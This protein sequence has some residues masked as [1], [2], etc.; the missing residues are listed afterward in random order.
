MVKSLS[1]SRSVASTVVAACSSAT[2][3]PIR[4][5]AGPEGPG[6][7]ARSSVS[8][9]IARS[10]QLLC[11]LRFRGGSSNP[12]LA[13]VKE[14][15]QNHQQQESTRMSSQ[16]VAESGQ[17]VVFIRCYREM[18]LAVN[19]LRRLGKGRVTPRPENVVGK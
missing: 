2:T 17:P 11:R 12:G 4:T 5:L 14:R 16:V 10:R 8:R 15:G 13:E 18:V 7:G 6:K 1:I 19:K 3:I 9:T